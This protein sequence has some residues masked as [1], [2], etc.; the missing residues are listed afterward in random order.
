M[1]HLA[2]HLNAFILLNGLL[3][4]LSNVV[5]GGVVWR[6]KYLVSAVSELHFFAFS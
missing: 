6:E 4:K 1:K 2:T 3:V 5:L